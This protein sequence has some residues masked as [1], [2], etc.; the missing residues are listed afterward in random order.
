VTRAPVWLHPED[1][2]LWDVLYHDL[3]PHR[4]LLDG[5][6]FTIAGVELTA[7]HTP[8]HSPGSTCLYA[9]D[10]GTVFTGD[11]L[12]QGGPGATGRSFS[13]RPTIESSIRARLLSLPDETEV[14]TGHGDATTIGEEAARPPFG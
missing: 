2:M 3:G 5:T 12:F 13:D 7:R 11:T 9:P 6:T 4:D 14:R 1:R 10:L 8:G